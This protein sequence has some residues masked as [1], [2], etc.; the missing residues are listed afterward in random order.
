MYD[1]HNWFGCSTYCRL[2]IN[3]DKSL[4]IYVYKFSLF[5]SF[6]PCD[7]RRSRSVYLSTHTS[8]KKEEKSLVLQTNLLQLKIKLKAQLSEFRN[9]RILFFWKNFCSL[10]S[11][12]LFCTVEKVLMNRK[13]EKKVDTSFYMFWF[14]Y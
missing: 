1:L 8:G 5:P 2:S 9:F 3:H 14:T 13:I 4:L 7:C 11:S 6:L 10:K 12:N